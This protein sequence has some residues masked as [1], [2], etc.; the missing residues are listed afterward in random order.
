MQK[1]SPSF[2]DCEIFIN[3]GF[4][5]LVAYW[6]PQTMLNLLEFINENKPPPRQSA[7]AADQNDKVDR[8]LDQRIHQHGKNEKLD[9]E[10]DEDEDESQPRQVIQRHKGCVDKRFFL[11]KVN[12]NLAYLES[13]FIHP[14]NN[15]YPIF[16]IKVEE[17]N[18][19]YWKKCDHDQIN[20]KVKNLQIF[21]NTSYPQTLDP[22]QR[23]TA[24]SEVYKREILG[25]NT[26]L[27]DENM[28]NLTCYVFQYP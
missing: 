7:N 8:D 10:V 19:D 18:V 17:T 3:L 5:G 24:E 11:L 9:D 16:S 14:D 23:Y 28:L 27:Q 13:V 26:Q 4:S 22:V 20:L 2:E 6:K 1:E 25:L 21:D 15:S 12:I